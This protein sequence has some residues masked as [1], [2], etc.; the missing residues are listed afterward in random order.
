MNSFGLLKNLHTLNLCINRLDALP[1]TVGALKKLRHL[2]LSDNRFTRVPGCLSRLTKL[3]SINLKRNPLFT[4]EAA[5]GHE[6]LAV[7]ER[8]SLVTESVLCEGC[9]KKCR[10]ERKTLEEE[11]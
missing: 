9:L 10:T 7:T 8:L 4:T 6:D 1:S 2:G 5:A 11:V 3:E